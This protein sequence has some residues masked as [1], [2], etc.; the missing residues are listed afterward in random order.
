MGLQTGLNHR[1]FAVA[2]DTD[3]NASFS[4]LENAAG[5][6]NRKKRASVHVL[7]YDSVTWTNFL[8]NMPETRGTLEKVGSAPKKMMGWA[9]YAYVHASTQHA[10]MLSWPLHAKFVVRASLHVRIRVHSMCLHF[11][12]IILKHIYMYLR[13]QTN[14]IHNALL[15]F[16][17][18]YNT[19]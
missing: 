3:P 1:I 15:C 11:N 18:L 12:N 8:F 16:L 5:S 19:L 10:C 17:I 7:I 9:A 2:G 14:K 4:K 6:F 13:Q